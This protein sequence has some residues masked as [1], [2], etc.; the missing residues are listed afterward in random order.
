[1][2]CCVVFGRDTKTMSPFRTLPT[3]DRLIGRYKKCC[4]PE[5]VEGRIVE[6]NTKL[7]FNTFIRSVSQAPFDRLPMT[8]SERRWFLIT[9]KFSFLRFL[10]R[11]LPADMIIDFIYRATIGGGLAAP[12][13]H[14]I[15]VTLC[16]ASSPADSLDQKYPSKTNILYAAG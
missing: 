4:H 8:E 16:A 15:L 11:S 3:K 14:S 1:M 9:K 5:P 13:S 7:T 2:C 6:L 10:R 12:V